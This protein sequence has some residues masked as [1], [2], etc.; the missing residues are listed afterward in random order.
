MKNKYFTIS[1]SI[2]V[3]L[4]VGFLL[5]R[6]YTRP[7]ISQIF[8]EKQNQAENAT[9]TPATNFLNTLPPRTA[10]AGSKEYRSEAYHF[11]LFYPENLSVKEYKEAGGA[12]TITFSDNQEDK[13]FQIFVLPFKGSQ[14][15]EK[16]FKMDVPSGVLKEPVDV[17]IDNIR[18]T[19]FFSSNAIMGDTREVW[20]IKNGFLYEVTTYKELD[21]W[22]AGIMQSWKF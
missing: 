11:S 3:V 18:A 6:Y 13:S 2:I 7:N 4:L 19:A 10:P 22:L 8:S 21:T 20:F 15:T 9:A 5:Y 17:M 1:I 14:V 12:Q 16:R